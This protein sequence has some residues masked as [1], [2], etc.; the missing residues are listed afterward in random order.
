MVVGDLV[1][2]LP[3]FRPG[4]AACPDWILCLDNRVARY[5]SKRRESC[6]EGSPGQGN[7][8]LELSEAG[9]AYVTRNGKLPETR[10][11]GSFSVWSNAIVKW[12]VKCGY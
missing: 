1:R 5:V 7:A 6:D 2:G 4:A 12:G 9:F 11:L 3:I 8:N 10:A